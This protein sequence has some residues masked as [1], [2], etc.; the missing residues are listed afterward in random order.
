MD[1]LSVETKDI[2]YLKIDEIIRSPSRSPS[3]YRDIQTIS[4]GVSQLK[5]ENKTKK[6]HVKINQYFGCPDNEVFCIKI[7]E[8]D[9]FLAAG[10]SEGVIRIY[11]IS[12]GNLVVSL[13][14]SDIYTPTTCLRLILY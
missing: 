9:N 4:T 1:K 2:K 3:K 11:S 14:A 8:D 12:N 10:T 7:D 5:I 6:N 13:E